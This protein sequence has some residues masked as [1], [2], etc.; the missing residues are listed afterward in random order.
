MN[1][2]VLVSAPLFVFLIRSQIEEEK[3][4]KEENK[5]N[6]MHSELKNTFFPEGKLCTHTQAGNKA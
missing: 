5:N 2:L 6:V 1:T 3:F 4:K